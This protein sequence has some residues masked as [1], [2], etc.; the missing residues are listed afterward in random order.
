MGRKRTLSGMSG[1]GRGGH[2]LLIGGDTNG[3]WLH[4]QL[5]R[6]RLREIRARVDTGVAVRI[7]GVGDVDS[8][9]VATAMRELQSLGAEVSLDLL[10]GLGCR[11]SA[12]GSSARR[13]V[14]SSKGCSSA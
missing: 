13:R 11:C 3:A 14:L 10:P 6:E 9:I 4:S 12:A 8:E 5:R 1:M 7:E 2:S